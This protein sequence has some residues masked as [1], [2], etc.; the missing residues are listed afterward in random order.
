MATDIILRVALAESATILLYD[1]EET[2]QAQPTDRLLPDNDDRT[3]WY[4]YGTIYGLPARCVYMTTPEDE[5]HATETGDYG[6]IDWWDRVERIDILG[7]DHQPII[8]LH[9]PDY[10]TA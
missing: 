7:D 6:D 4:G 9:N 5:G 8:S 1:Y 2:E 10:T 3:E